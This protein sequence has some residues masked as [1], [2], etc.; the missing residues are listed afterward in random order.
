MAL[1][2]FFGAPVTIPEMMQI[3]DG[4]VTLTVAEGAS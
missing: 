2:L 3:S 1:I 4:R